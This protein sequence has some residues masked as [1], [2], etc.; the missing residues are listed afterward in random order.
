MK[1]SR[2]TLSVVLLAAS[3]ASV[4]QADPWTNTLTPYLWGSSVYGTMA[5]GTPLG[6]IGGGVD[7]SSGDVLSHL[8]IGGMLSYRGQ[9]DQW[10]V[11]ADALYAHLTASGSKPIGP[12]TLNVEGG[13]KLTVLETDIGYRLTP[14]I[15]ALAGVRYTNVNMDLSANATGPTTTPTGSAERSQNWVDPVIG[16]SADIPLATDWSL[17]LRADVGGFGVGAKFAWQGLGMV[18]WQATKLLSVVGGYRYLREEYES[19]SGTDYFRYDIAM[20]GPAIGASF[21]F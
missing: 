6:P 8:K 1:I 20:S 18:S 10:A 21:T 19:G 2:G 7:L 14:Q 13:E 12:Y 15:L 11:I 3:A 4:V 17:R 16:M 9:N 5:L